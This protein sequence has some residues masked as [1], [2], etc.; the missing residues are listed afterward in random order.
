MW[1]VLGIGLEDS[2]IFR[3]FWG[4]P[5]DSLFIKNLLKDSW[6]FPILQSC[7]LYSH[8]DSQK[9]QIEKNL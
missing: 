5:E 8:F 1:R 4:E 2:I 9:K 3:I 6:V 7:L